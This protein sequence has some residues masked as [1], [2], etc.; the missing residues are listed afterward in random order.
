MNDADR[1][2]AAVAA[3]QRQ[4]FSRAQALEAGLTRSGVHRRTTSGLLVACGSRSL[5]FAG[6]QLEW[7]ARLMAALLD[8]GD[9]AVVSARSAAALHE[10][11]GFGEGPVE[12]LV[13][14]ARKDR[15]TNGR[16]MSTP[17]LGALDMEVVDGLPATSGTRTILEL[18]GR[19]GEREL[20]NAIDSALRRG[21]TSPAVLWRRLDELGRQGR[22]GSPRSNASWSWQVCRAG[23]SGS[24]ATSSTARAFPGRGRS[25]RTGRTAATSPGSTS[26]SSRCP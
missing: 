23:W 10:L 21:L 22:A 6:A 4:V 8:L 5:C 17:A 9:G 2:L 15:S 13:P 7:R 24:S 3:S 14:T 18:M 12:L 26:I 20:G 1:R 25:G 19:V 16:V 11:D